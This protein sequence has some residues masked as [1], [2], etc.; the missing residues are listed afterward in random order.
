[1]LMIT[2]HSVIKFLPSLRK[3]KIYSE[4]GLIETIC[5]Q[6][7]IYGKKLL[8]VLDRQTLSSAFFHKNISTVSHAAKKLLLQSNAKRQSFLCISANPVTAIGS[9]CYFNFFCLSEH[10]QHDKNS[11]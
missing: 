2:T 7:K 3:I 10:S 9:V 11:E 5:Q 4:F 8:V 1:M 6:A